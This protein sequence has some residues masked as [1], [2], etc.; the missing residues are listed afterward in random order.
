MVPMY[1][2]G[3]GYITVQT[4]SVLH[5]N[6]NGMTCDHCERN[7]ERALRGVSGVRSVAVDRAAGAVDLDID[8]ARPPSMADLADA[9]HAAGYEIGSTPEKAQPVTDSDAV[10]DFAIAGMTCASC[11]ATIERRLAREPGVSSAA[12]N[13]G[14]ERARVRYD[15]A[16]ASPQTIA[17]A[18]ADAGYRAAELSG[19][20]GATSQ[21][22]A[23]AREAAAAWWWFAA[24]A[25]PAAAILL[26]SMVFTAVP[27]R[28]WWM[29]AL[30]TP[31][32]FV[33]GARYYRGA[34]DA[35]RQRSANMDTLV[36]L[37][38]S[39]AYFY[40]LANLLR[41]TSDV[42]FETSALLIAFVLLG[43]A[44]E[45]R[46]KTSAG[47]AIRA[48]MHL[49][50]KRARVMRGN[51]DVEIDAAEVRLD[52][53]VLVRPGEAFAVDGVV[54]DGASSADES[55]LTGESIP[56]AKRPG[57]PVYA[58]TINVDG[59]LRYR[60]TKVG[61]ATALAAIV[62]M[63]DEAQTSKAPVQRF[64]DAV[65]AVFVPV[66]IAIAVLTFVVWYVVL[67]APLGFAIMAS[68][69]VVVVACP[70]ALGLA[71]PT[72]LMVGLGRGAGL[73]LLI[74]DG[75]ALEAAG[76]LDT[77]LLDKTGTLTEGKPEVTAMIALSDADLG[78]TLADVA[79]VEAL[80]EHPV[81]QA[82][83]A[84][85]RRRGIAET[86]G[87]GVTL[88]F[89][90]AGRGVR[91]RVRGANIL[92]GS[93]AFVASYGVQVEPGAL[94]SLPPDA[95]VVIA[96]KDQRAVAAFAVSDTVKTNAREAVD[97][98]RTLDVAVAIVSG[99]NPAAVRAAAEAVGVTDVR[100]AMTPGEKAD[101][102]RALQRD[103]HSVA[104]VGDGIN[105]AP[106]LTAADVGIALGSGADVAAQAGSIVLVSNDLRD[107]PRALRLARATY[108][109]IQHGMFW[110]LA[111]NV[112]GI[113]IAA[114]VL[115]PVWHTMLRPEVAG[116]AMALSSVSV[117]LNAL[118]LK[119]ASIE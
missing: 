109:T 34:F 60:A 48:L 119:R 20:D 72:A 106:G 55:L 108:R 11:V 78:S 75:A 22:A 26:L 65:S 31:V 42:F 28:E 44:L 38:T 102:V 51:A 98:L 114:G 95:T 90:E 56:R 43:K 57:D 29:L 25:V 84:E 66:V 70:C 36:A 68:V 103:G 83:V 52:D 50:P 5:I 62:R 99:D 110:A 30:A 61:S 23:Q 3:R 85:A 54:S 67:H 37:G 88:F 69:S 8:P 117:V 74:R 6:V 112:L 21:S 47:D 80:S 101:A 81:A 13:L 16:I 63:V 7:V 113:P 17:A 33:A 24:A 2:R 45:T 71:T 91:G 94:S 82:L 89:A 87:S 1:Y 73:G 49:A 64:A 27:G 53:E 18:V 35:L 100:A 105:D 12:V 15:R 59:S 93:P 41:G 116:L 9:L 118:S 76:R 46:A 14:T 19:A 107:V 77:V 97:R 86:P 4:S 39:A 32:Q 58:G 96:A 79:A 115:Y 40:S 104:M 92:V 111:Y 10:A